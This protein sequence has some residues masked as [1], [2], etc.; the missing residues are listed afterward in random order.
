MPPFPAEKQEVAAGM[1]QDVQSAF[2]ASTLIEQQPSHVRQRI[3]RW[4]SPWSFFRVL[5]L[6]AFV[7][8]QVWH[9]ENLLSKGAA[10]ALSSLSQ[11]RHHPHL[12][13]E[14]YSICSRTGAHIYTSEEGNE[15][16]KC[17]TVRNGTIVDVGDL[18]STKS[19][20]LS[21]A[22]S[23]F[24]DDHGIE[25]R[26]HTTIEHMKHQVFYLPEGSLM[27]PGLVDSHAHSLQYG[28]SQQ[29]PLRGSASVE[30]VI[31]KVE[32][33]VKTHKKQIEDGRWAEGAGW[34]QN[35]WP[36]KSF[37]KAT[38]LDK[39][40]ALKGVPI[41]LKRIDI[42]AEWVSPRVLEIMGDLPLEVPGGQIIRDEHG[43]PT[44][45]DDAMLLID[46]VRPQWTE[47]QMQEYLNLT[48][49]DGLSKGLVGIHDGG[50]VPEHVD[51]FQSDGALGSW[52]AALIQPYS[53]KPG[54]YGT[55]R[56]PEEV[57][58][59]LIKSFVRK[60]W[61]VNVHCIGDKANR[62]V[63]DAMQAALEELPEHERA[64]RRLRLE[65]AQIMQ[66]EDLE[67]AAKLGNT[68]SASSMLMIKWIP[69]IHTVIASYQPTHATSDM[70]YA[71]DRLGPERI[72]GAYAWRRYLQAG[73]RI[74]LGSDFP[75]ESIDPLKGFY[76]A[77][78]RLD[79]NGHSPMG[80][81][82]WYPDQKLT[83]EEALK[84]MTI[85]AA[86]AS[87]MENETGS[88]RK[89]KQFDA[90]V[91]NQNIL[92][93]PRE[94]ILKTKVLSTVIDGKAAWG[95]LFGNGPVQRRANAQDTSYGCFPK[96]L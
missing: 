43:K 23:F 34:D 13:P 50:V 20:D 66:L 70:W 48:I 54:E 91:W 77:V 28:W 14:L 31:A 5:V 45:V 40:P 29:L 67:R 76:A 19:D 57:W 33:Y 84:G 11:W 92:G 4:L 74:T 83:R 9:T 53:D 87:F 41:A 86:Y 94:D 32:A 68:T 44:G 63:L 36:V 37:P 42:H 65:H 38:D 61:Q 75:V 93:V 15:W 52:G 81:D 58:E 30:D 25:S 21:A 39:S 78:T 90:V 55:M 60:G 49:E 47:T 26:R 73:G 17:V 7:G 3:R 27:T 1:A 96:R 18:I 62:I 2:H 24:G 6:A 80:K 51:F 82:G 95:T 64:G 69:A 22:V 8:L 46:K 72:K 88:F 35:I 89:G 71:E 56:S 16:T 79:E 12:L 59:P 10:T 85:Y